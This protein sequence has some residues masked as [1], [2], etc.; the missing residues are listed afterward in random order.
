MSGVRRTLV[1][2]AGWSMTLD[3]V[4]I[5]LFG[6]IARLWNMFLP[7]G[8]G[9]IWEGVLPI[10]GILLFSWLGYAGYRFLMRRLWAYYVAIVFHLTYLTIGAVAWS[11]FMTIPG[12]RP[13]LNAVLWPTVFLLISTGSLIGLFWP[14]TWKEFTADR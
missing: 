13:D 1:G 4:T 10:D 3:S 11:E 9:T 7:P 5:V 14:G 8:A 12:W 2:L 6:L